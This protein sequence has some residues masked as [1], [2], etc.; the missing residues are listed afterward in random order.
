[1]IIPYFSIIS[2]FWENHRDILQ[3]YLPNAP[4]NIYQHFPK[5]LPRVRKYTIQH[6]MIFI[7]I[8]VNYNTNMRKYI[9]LNVRIFA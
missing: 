7:T 4:C 1:M 3:K 5:N 8:Y 9:N 6:G 2:L